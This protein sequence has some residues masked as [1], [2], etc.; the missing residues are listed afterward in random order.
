MGFS[1]VFFSST[2]LEWRKGP[3]YWK[4][5]HVSLKS[6]KLLKISSVIQSCIQ[7]LYAPSIMHTISVCTIMILSFRT[8]RSRQTVDPD[9]TA[10][11]EQS[12]QGLHCLPFRLLIR[13]YTVCHSVYIFWAH[14]SVLKLYSSSFRIVTASFSDVQIFRS[15]W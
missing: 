8:D 9:Q 10:P 5:K 4:N 2:F 13:V 7:F 11:K 1:S 14:C 6:Q 15:L 12:D 3:F